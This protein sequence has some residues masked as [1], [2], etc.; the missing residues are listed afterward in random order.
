MKGKNVRV[1]AFFY[2]GNGNKLLASNNQ[3]R[4]SDGQLT[5]QDTS[6]VYYDSSSWSDFILE[7]PYSA[8]SKGS[9][10][11][12]IIQLQDERGNYLCSSDDNYF[13]VN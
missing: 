2:Y 7:I 12:F 11:K 10:H 5:V 9:N 6:V 3:Y 1:C 4:T 8:I 13:S